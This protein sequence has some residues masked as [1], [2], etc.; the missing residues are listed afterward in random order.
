MRR[1]L[2]VVLGINVGKVHHRKGDDPGA[3]EK[4]F[5]GVTDRWAGQ[6]WQQ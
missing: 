5:V 2:K 6:V 3:R 1:S 4:T